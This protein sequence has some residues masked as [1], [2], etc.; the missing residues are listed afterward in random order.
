MGSV[1][2]GTNVAGAYGAPAGSN[3]GLNDQQLLEVVNASG[4]VLTQG[5]VVVWDVTATGLPTAPA[6]GGRRVTTT[7]TANSPRYAGVVSD[8]GAATSS[9]T[10]GIG[11]VG[12]IAISGVARVNIAANTVA[13]DAQV[14]SSTAAKVAAAPAAAGSVA[15][16][17]GFIGSWIGVALEAQTAKDANNTIRVS[18]K[19]A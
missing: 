11:A 1:K 5:D 7:T 3:A 13:A 9:Y 16:L 12:T 8:G 10:I 6:D 14:A 4:G 15:I 2:T 17:Q 19:Q 18:L